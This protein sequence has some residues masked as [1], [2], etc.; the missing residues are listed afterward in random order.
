MLPNSG[1]WTL[2]EA[3]ITLLCPNGHLINLTHG[4]VGILSDPLMVCSECPLDRGHQQ[5]WQLPLVLR[6]NA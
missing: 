5:R 3:R 4:N 1:V 6:S 2:V